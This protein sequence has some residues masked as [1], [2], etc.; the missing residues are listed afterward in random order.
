MN[1]YPPSL[2]VNDT[3]NEFSVTNYSSNATG[4]DL[5]NIIQNIDSNCSGSELFWIIPY[6]VIV[7]YVIMSFDRL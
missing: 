5:F 7:L 2:F 6:V 1:Y 4:Y 3:V